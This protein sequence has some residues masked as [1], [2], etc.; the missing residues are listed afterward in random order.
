ML[1]SFFSTLLSSFLLTLLSIYPTATSVCETLPTFTISKVIL[2]SLI[3]RRTSAV[4]NTIVS[5]KSSLAPLVTFSISDSDGSRAGNSLISI[6]S[7]EFSPSIKNAAIPD[8]TSVITLSKS[9]SWLTSP[10]GIFFKKILRI[11]SLFS[12]FTFCNSRIICT[13]TLSFIN[14]LIKSIIARFLSTVIS[15]K[16]KSKLFSIGNVLLILFFS[17]SKLL[18][19]PNFTPLF[20]NLLLFCKKNFKILKNMVVYLIEYCYNRIDKLCNYILILI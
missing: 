3:L 18:E 11:V 7:A 19:K 13:I 17:C 20:L 14:P 16:I 6:T 15:L 5:T 10:Q 9:Y 4:L 12:S 2:G 8:K 1:L